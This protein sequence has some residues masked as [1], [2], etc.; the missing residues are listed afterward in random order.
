MGICIGAGV[1]TQ[2]S[3]DTHNCKDNPGNIVFYS[4]LWK[5]LAFKIFPA[6]YEE[7]I[8]NGV[9]LDVMVTIKNCPYC[10]KSKEEIWPGLKPEK[11]G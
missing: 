1:V 11:F 9:Q 4:K 7:A 6:N 10:G 8:L 5:S 2:M 3:K